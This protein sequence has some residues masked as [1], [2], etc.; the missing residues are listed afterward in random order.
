M[1]EISQDQ[2]DTIFSALRPET[3]KVVIAEVH[4]AM[5]DTCVEYHRNS[6]TAAQV[7]SDE[8]QGLRTGLD[9]LK[10]VD[11]EYD[12]IIKQNRNLVD[13]DSSEG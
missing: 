7:L 6:G 8:V 1:P 2:L 10:R 12:E 13:G 11:T 9:S 5:L 3:R 4:K